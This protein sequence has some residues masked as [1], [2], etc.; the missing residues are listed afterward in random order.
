[1]RTESEWLKLN[2]SDNLQDLSIEGHDSIKYIYKI[3]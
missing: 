2:G 3:G 1:M